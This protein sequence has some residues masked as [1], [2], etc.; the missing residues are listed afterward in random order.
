[1]RAATPA[2][3]RPW[4]YRYR[5]ASS[6]SAPAGGRDTEPSGDVS[7]IPQAWMMS[8][9]YRSLN[10]RINDGG[11]AEPPTTTSRSDDTS[12]GWLSR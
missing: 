1:M 5:Q 6:P 8:M 10:A 11:H 7:V 9:S 4:V 12:A 3:T 2:G